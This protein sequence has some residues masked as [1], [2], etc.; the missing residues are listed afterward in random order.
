MGQNGP[1]KW[2]WKGQIRFLGQQTWKTQKICEKWVL[3]IFHSQYCWGII[4][5]GLLLKYIGI[6][7]FGHVCL[8]NSPLCGPTWS[9]M[10]FPNV[11][12]IMLMIL[13]PGLYMVIMEKLPIPKN[14]PTC[15]ISSASFRSSPVEIHWKIEN[16]YAGNHFMVL[17]SWRFLGF[18]N[19]W[20]KIELKVCESMC[21]GQGH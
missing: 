14:N 12:G 21:E 11:R 19:F 17:Q 16:R 4:S 1:E 6:W 9:A 7:E 20:G 3:L 13:D 18:W 10:K 8:P 15:H 2:P 5:K